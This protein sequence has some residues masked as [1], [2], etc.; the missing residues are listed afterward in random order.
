MYSYN[1]KLIQNLDLFKSTEK[2]QHLCEEMP[3]LKQSYQNGG[4]NTNT[5][6]KLFFQ[7]LILAFS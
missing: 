1:L 6:N 5:G 7:Q 2:Q 3:K 4:K